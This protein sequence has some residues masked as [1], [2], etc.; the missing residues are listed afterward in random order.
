MTNLQEDLT[1]ALERRANTAIA[2]D[3]LE[4][5]LTG[6]NIIRVSNEADSPRRRGALLAVAAS[7]AVLVGAAGL[8]WA[9]TAR[10]DEVTPAD[11]AALPPMADD[12]PLT[13]KAW[14]P[15]TELAVNMAA[16]VLRVDCYQDAGLDVQGRTPADWIVFGQ[17]Q[18]H[19]VLGIRRAGAARMLGYANQFPDPSTDIDSEVIDSC[20][21]QVNRQ[22]DGEYLAT[23]EPLRGLIE[24]QLQDRADL[25]AERDPRVQAA[26]E[27]WSECISSATGKT[28]TTPNDLARQ[29]KFGGADGD[30]IPVA[31]ADVDCQASADLETTWY[32][33]VTEYE[34]AMVGD[35]I[36]DYDTLVRVRYDF[37]DQARS[38]LTERGITIPSLD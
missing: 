15:E 16:E 3:N 9:T 13:G 7:A 29:F 14:L 31:V 38:L 18:A 25:A 34:R 27:T 12:L 17:W 5:I 37:I 19:P 6:T 10:T 23:G 33:V 4:A 36:D 30:D 24:N 26:L 2:E 22:F 20:R 8:V 32:T 1:G 28:A 11:L 21:Q 35:D